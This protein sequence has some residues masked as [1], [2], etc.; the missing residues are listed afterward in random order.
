MNGHIEDQATR[1]GPELDALRSA[2]EH[3]LS[4]AREQLARRRQGVEEYVMQRP[5]KALAMTLGA[6]VV[7]GWLIRRR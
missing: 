4:I 1:I 5:W 3:E 6:G 2:A 7:V